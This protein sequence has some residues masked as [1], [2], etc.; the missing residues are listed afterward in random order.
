MLDVL[1]D[2]FSSK[3]ATDTEVT[4]CPGIGAKGFLG[5][6]DAASHG[7]G[8]GGQR[9][10]R[11]CGTDDRR[12]LEPNTPAFAEGDINVDKVDG[13]SRR[14]MSFRT[15]LVCALRL[16]N[17]DRARSTFFLPVEQHEDTQTLRILIHR[18]KGFRLSLA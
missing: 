2:A 6:E 3:T 13:V 12:Q 1:L 10:Y 17:R 15:L 4:H 8:D 7:V 9:R 18:K 14:H 11:I 5:R 16:R